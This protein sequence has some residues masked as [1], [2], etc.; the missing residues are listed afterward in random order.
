MKV[1][2]DGNTAQVNNDYSVD[3][4]AGQVTIKNQALLAPGRNL[5]ISYEAN[6][7]LQ[8]ASK[9]LL[10]ARGEFDV[11]KNSAFGFTVMN[12]SQQSLSDKIRLGKNRSAIPSMESTEIQ[13]KTFRS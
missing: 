5:S 10:G 8:L 11:G 1:V 9:S 4:V 6:D 12:L 3:Y 7:L 13:H 2:V